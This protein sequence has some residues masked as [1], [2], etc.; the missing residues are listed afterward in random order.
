MV[1]LILV[2]VVPANSETLSVSLSTD[3]DGLTAYETGFT[4]DVMKAP[5][6]EGI[7]L[8]DMI[9]FENDAPGAGTS[10]K[11]TS[12][13][14]LFKNVFA[15]KIIHLDDPS[16]F[17]AHIILY[18]EAKNKD[19]KAQKPFFIIVNGKRIEGPPLSWHE[20]RWLWVP[21]PPE[22]LQK[23]DNTIIVGCDAPR[24]K[25]Y[26]LMLARADEYEKGGGAYLYDGNTALLCA[27]QVDVSDEGKS[28]KIQ[29]FA[30][31]DYS[32]KSLDNG[33]TWITKKLGTANDVIGEY[34]IRLQVKRF[35]PEGQL[36]SPPVDLWDGIT[37]YTKIKPACSV[38]D[39]TLLFM[40]ETPE[41]TAIE[42]QVRY[43]DTPDMTQDAWGPFR[44]VGAGEVLSVHVDPG[45]NR[46]LQWRAV[47]TTK[48]PLK[49]PVVQ[50]VRLHRTVAF[51]P[52]QNNYYVFK[53]DNTAQ[54]YSSYKFRYE[55]WDEPNLQRLRDRLGLDRLVKDASGDW[56]K[57]NLVRH[58]ISGQW[59]HK[60][61]DNDYPEWNA[62]E[63]LDRRDR[64]GYGGMC[65]QFTQVFIQSL[66]SLGFQARYVMM[67]EHDIAEVY[68]DELGKWVLVDPESI[69]DSYEYET[70]TG[71]PVNCLEQHR[72]FLMENGIT[73]ENPINW[74]AV[75]PWANLPRPGKT[76]GV[77]APLDFSTFTG[78]INDPSKPDYPPQHRLAGLVRIML[79]NNWFSQPYP[80]PLT[81]G[82]DYWPWDGF[83]NW[84]DDATPRQ[85][86]Y[87][88]HSDR[89]VD[90][91]PTLNT[92]TC[93][94]V[95]SK[96]EGE[97]AVTMVTFT[98][99]FDSYEINIDGA[100][101][102]DSP[103]RFTWKLKPSAL[104]TLEMR[105]RNKLGLKGKPSCIE[106]M[107]HYKEL[108]APKPK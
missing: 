101:W 65:V 45:K 75:D 55:T 105:I 42:W 23:G 49:T 93:D 84:Y 5:R 59:F 3:I 77:P 37:G 34:T 99:N 8:N 48:N 61:P 21:I 62:L 14:E 32:S 63:I 12:R 6:N 30:V 81:Q 73:A 68:V 7:M 96:N 25:G 86:Q 50:G 29:K 70:S 52:P 17:E 83:L 80:R 88:L 44:T 51:T 71:M 15:R 2:F 100:G 82:V 11:G 19:N 107:Y 58:H 94:A 27:N 53:Y 72:Y 104:N 10:E 106:V 39:L 57:I 60:M 67:I 76:P 38:S 1:L 36:L 74:K 28:V 20:P 33:A 22:T 9:L 79:R 85:L 26:D 92:V 69:F 56:E 95:Y 108:Y 16:A 66:L 46:Y 24:G 102:K 43:A 47:L 89:E 40:G 13:E 31:G 90:F 97:I 103:D 91:Y 64:T 41:G 98:P 4:C 87:A 54:R 18:M 35:K 78:W